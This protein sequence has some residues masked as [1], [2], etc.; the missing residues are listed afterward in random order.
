MRRYRAKQH[1]GVKPI[2]HVTVILFD[3]TGIPRRSW[4]HLYNNND[5]EFLYSLG[6]DI[7]HLKSD[8]NIFLVEK[9]SYRKVCNLDQN[10]TF[11]VLA[12]IKGTFLIIIHRELEHK[13]SDIFPQMTEKV[14][15]YEI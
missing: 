8:Y 9:N 6:K 4:I 5:P 10:E 1:Y 11:E 2:C 12:N 14:G 7:P 15:G 13:P 3:K